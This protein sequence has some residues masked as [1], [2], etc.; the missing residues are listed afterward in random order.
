MDAI[1]DKFLTAFPIWESALA[2]VLLSL[3]MGVVT[4]FFPSLNKK[5]ILMMRLITAVLGIFIALLFVHFD[6]HTF[7]TIETIKEFIIQFL[8]IYSVSELFCRFG[9]KDFVSIFMKTIRGNIDKT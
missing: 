5:R 4:G 1:T 2:G 8:V 7:S 9:G 6:K 3:V